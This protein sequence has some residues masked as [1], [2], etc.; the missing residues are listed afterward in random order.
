MAVP[1]PIQL[2]GKVPKWDR[3]GG[4]ACTKFVVNGNDFSMC[5]SEVGMTELGAVPRYFQ[6]ADSSLANLDCRSEVAF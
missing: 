6:I 1:C 3:L 4:I 5:S 2:N